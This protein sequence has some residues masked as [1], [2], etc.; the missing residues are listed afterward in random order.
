[1]VPS[2]DYELRNKLFDI[3]DAC[4]YTVDR[5]LEMIGR[6][7]S[8]MILQLLG[9]SSRWELL[10]GVMFEVLIKISLPII[11]YNYMI[12]LLKFFLFMFVFNFTLESMTNSFPKV[13]QTVELSVNK[14]VKSSNPQI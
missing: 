3:A 6:S 9:G 5:R 12:N 2:I 1:M 10:W 14:F 13:L 7:S 8:E 4:G 11:C